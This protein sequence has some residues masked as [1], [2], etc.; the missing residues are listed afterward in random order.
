MIK[1]SKVKG[2]LHVCNKRNQ[3]TSGYKKMGKLQPVPECTQFQRAVF[4]PLHYK[5]SQMFQIFFMKEKKTGAKCN[6]IYVA[7][8]ITVSY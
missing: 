6:T 5:S 8:A 3:R 1:E 4:A 7:S 2:R